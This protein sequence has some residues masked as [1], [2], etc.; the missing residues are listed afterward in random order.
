MFAL[1]RVPHPCTPTM[2]L[3]VSLRPTEALGKDTT[4]E[5]ATA[6]ID[7]GNGEQILR[8]LAFAACDRAAHLANLP[9]GTFVPQAVMN[10]E[11]IVEDV[12]SVIRAR[13][14]DG[15]GVVVRFG[16]GPEA[17]T[18]RWEGRPGTPPAK[19][20]E[21]GGR[22]SRADS[23]ETNETTS[24]SSVGVTQSTP[25][26][27]WLESR[28]DFDAF[29]IPELVSET[30]ALSRKDA[31][32]EDV[33]AAR[34][35]LFTHA[36]ALQALFK[37]YESD[38]DT[39]VRD[40]DKMTL[41]QFRRFMRDA[42]AIEIG[43]PT[44]TVLDVDHCF[45]EA[46]KKKTT[47]DKEAKSAQTKA[48]DCAGFLIAVF[49]VSV[50][51]YDVSKIKL[52]DVG[53]SELHKRLNHFLET[54]VYP[55]LS[56]TF[57]LTRDALS[58]ATLDTAAVTTLYANSRLITHAMK[59][60]MP[61]RPPGDEWT[62]F[63]HDF[64]KSAM[65]WGVLADNPE[66][67]ADAAGK[68]L[69]K[70]PG[71]VSFVSGDGD[72]TFAKTPDGGDGSVSKKNTYDLLAYDRDAPVFV[73]LHAFSRAVIQVRQDDA[74]ELRRFRPEES[75][76]RLTVE[77]FE[78]LL[79]SLAWIGHGKRVSRAKKAEE[80]WAAAKAETE[81]RRRRRETDEPGADDGKSDSDLSADL[82]TNSANAKFGDTKETSETTT[83]ATRPVD[84]FT[85]PSFALHLHEFL[86]DIYHKSGVLTPASDDDDENA[87][88]SRES[89]A[90]E[91]V[92]DVSVEEDGEAVPD[93]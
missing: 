63:V 70:T 38:G 64:T 83:D 30:I 35:S 33:A 58:K 4:G 27:R 16:R 10:R 44:I 67:A 53:F 92:S 51:K 76:A 50:R 59:M 84:R 45:G 23:G 25:G 72:A 74:S 43:P 18:A 52:P 13:Y 62:L 73:D 90:E 65:G 55:F 9:S 88:F 36:G 86:T 46:L 48:L 14:A 2:Q 57:E 31:R 3:R 7:C 89:D 34:V 24:T 66:E 81:A 11:G 19:A 8:W 41:E 32:A 12:D 37:L 22:E 28:L 77:Q 54:H 26:L 29:G 60:C 5:V 71:K 17:F 69:G 87:E 42:K 79:L 75:P 93:A 21:F 56:R 80:H 20:A 39:N 61:R 1:R 78:K 91:F 68:T 15:D 85:T 6:S 47:S 49:R 40:V 82:E